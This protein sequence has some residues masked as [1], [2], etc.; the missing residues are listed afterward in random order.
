MKLII[1]ESQYNKLI[2]TDL[3]E[4]YPTSWNIEEFKKL[5]SFSARVQYCEKHLQRISSGSSRIVYK[6]DDIKVLKLAKNKKGLAQ[7]ETEIDFGRDSYLS[8]IVAK[9]FDYDENNLWVEMELA[10][11]VTP[12]IFKNIVGITFENYCHIMKYR[13]SISIDFDLK[14]SKPENYNDIW[15]IDFVYNM[16][17]MMVNYELPWGD[18]CR[19]STYGL[20]NRN[21]QDELAMI[22]YGL[23][24]DVYDS[25]YK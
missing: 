13:Y 11:K 20:V 10:R 25:Y 15:E 1:T 3:G 5:K 18:L 6:I 19:L 7:N 21:G 22:D 17:D 14:I 9:I 2:Q 12:T 24:S 8:N 23:T 4:E 16:M